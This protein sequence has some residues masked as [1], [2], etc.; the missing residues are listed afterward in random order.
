MNKFYKIKEKDTNCKIQCKISS[1]C[2]F[3]IQINF[4]EKKK[5]YFI[6]NFNLNH[7]LDHH[8]EIIEGYS[9]FSI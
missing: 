4:N 7:N 9:N 5:S 3:Y 6:K 2:S 1:K 8:P